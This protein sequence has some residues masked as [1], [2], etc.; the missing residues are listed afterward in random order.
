MGMSSHVYG[1]RKPDEAWEK[2]KKVWNVCEEAGV[3]IPDETLDFFG[4]EDPNN[5][6]G[7]EV[8]LKESVSI[9]NADMQEGFEVDLKDIPLGVRYIRF[10]NSY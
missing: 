9:F 1:F 6:P 8:D 7:M 10:V 2:H 4:E 5:S 3:S